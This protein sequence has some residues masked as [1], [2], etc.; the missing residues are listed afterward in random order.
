MHVKTFILAGALVGSGLS[1]AISDPCTTEIEGLTKTLAAK[2]A[3]S[4]PT[5]DG[6]GKCADRLFGAASPNRG[7]GSGDPG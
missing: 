5:V 3:G 6:S 2:D 1:S 7:H 4:G